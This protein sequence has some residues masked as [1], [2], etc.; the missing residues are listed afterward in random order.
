MNRDAAL[1]CLAVARRAI[2]AGDSEKALRFLQ[3]S[4]RMH[5]TAEAKELLSALQSRG[6]GQSPSEPSASP[7]S[8]PPTPSSSPPST[9][10]S[11]SYSEKD[12]EVAR[13]VVRCKD[14]YEVLQVPRTASEAEI[15]KAYRK[16]RP[17]GRRSAFGKRV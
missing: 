7:R 14:L 10:T 3:K 4:I 11:V 2:K 16:V 9:P 17:P 8:S 15:K 5:E 13:R 12:V 6:R 1:Q